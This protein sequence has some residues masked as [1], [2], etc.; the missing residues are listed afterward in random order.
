MHTLLTTLDGVMKTGSN[1]AHIK[2]IIDTLIDNPFYTDWKTMELRIQ[3][4]NDED[5]LS[6]EGLDFDLHRIHEH[7][8]TDLMAYRW[9]TIYGEGENRLKV[10]ILEPQQGNR[11]Y[12]FG[13]SFELE[14]QY[15]K[16]KKANQFTDMV[17]GKLSAFIYPISF[18]AT[19][20]YEEKEDPDYGTDQYDFEG[21][22]DIPQTGLS[23]GAVYWQYLTGQLEFQDDYSVEVLENAPAFKKRH[24]QKRIDGQPYHTF[25]YQIYDNPFEKTKEENLEMMREFFGYIRA[26]R[27][28]LRKAGYEGPEGK[29]RFV[30]RY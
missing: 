5:I 6:E 27:I 12:K 13:I 26:E 28:K 16:G 23:Y 22:Y 10:S 17:K 20:M 29:D 11:N 14:E 9:M 3:R 19:V 8:F 15:L 7:F 21:K 18:T 1:V 2:K 30:P 4:V 24:L 25:D